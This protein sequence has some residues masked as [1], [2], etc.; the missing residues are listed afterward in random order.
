[1]VSVMALRRRVMMQ[2][3]SAPPQPTNLIDKT[4][5]VDRRI[6]WAGN[7]LTGYDYNCATPK[8]SVTPGA[9]YY[10]FRDSRKPDGTGAQNMVS[11]FD[12]NQAY[13]R[14]EV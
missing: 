1:M 10:L 14:Q 6:W 9:T 11:Y 8:I 4:Q 12:S 13:L 7:M 5:L 3:T 2:G